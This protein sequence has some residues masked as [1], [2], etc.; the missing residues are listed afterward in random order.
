MNRQEPLLVL[1]LDG[2]EVQVGRLPVDE[3]TSLL[4]KV[5]LCVK[6]LGQV[7]SGEI[8]SAGPGRIKGKIEEQC[9]LDVV[10]IETGSFQIGLDISQQSD[11]MMLPTMQPLGIAAVEKFVD[12]IDCL[13]QDDP[14]LLNEFDY[15]VL[16]ALRD[17]AKV[18]DRG[19]SKVDVSYKGNGSGRRSTALNT[20]VRD[21]VLR[22][23]AGPSRSASEVKGTLREVDLENSTC[24]I[25]PASGRYIDC[26]FEDKHVPLIKDSLDLYVTARG[27]AVHREAGG[28]VKELR[29]SDI[30]V[31][32]T[33]PEYSQPDTT[34]KPLTAK[35][36]LQSGLVGMW[37]DRTD[38][39]DSGEFAVKLRE[40]AEIRGRS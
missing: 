33:P 19:V 10:A 31:I 7:L 22:N 2:P 27:E 8:S 17:V 12:G 32:E 37:K 11:Q 40:Q 39:G 1:K 36:L 4:K 20:R 29:I 5:Q 21:E 13:G 34:L 18:L 35:M 26:K 23:I 3:L 28:S 9:N 38:I 14:H 16:V 30:E 15:G 24:Q 25:Y 6:R